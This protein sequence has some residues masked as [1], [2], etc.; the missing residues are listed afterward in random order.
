MT[1]VTKPGLIL[2]IFVFLGG[3]VSVITLER[4]E[5]NN[6]FCIACHLNENNP[7]HGEKFNDFIKNDPVNLAGLHVV[8]DQEGDFKCIDCHRGAD[9]KSRIKI[10][11]LSARDALIYLF[12]D[13][14]EP[15]YLKVPLQDGDCLQCHP[16]YKP[17]NSEDYHA[18]LDHARDVPIKCIECHISHKKGGIK[19]LYFL[20]E[21]TVLPLCRKCHPNLGV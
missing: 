14:K 21:E 5:E 2:I 16:V 3:F 15:E 17:K 18:L 11:L 7:L 9:I 13:S 8:R 4:M 12:G 20:D 1:S 10:K 6:R 19:E